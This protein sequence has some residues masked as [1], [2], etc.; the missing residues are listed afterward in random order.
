MLDQFLLY[1]L[2]LRLDVF[3]FC[4]TQVVALQCCCSYRPCLPELSVQGDAPVSGLVEEEQVGVDSW[5]LL[6]LS[7]VHDRKKSIHHNSTVCLDTV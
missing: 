4:L 1:A 5:R 7:D 6:D 2:I 3:L